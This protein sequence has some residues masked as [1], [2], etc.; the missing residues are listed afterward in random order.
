M[1]R[2]QIDFVDFGGSLNGKT[3]IL[4]CEMTDLE[5][6][7]A[8]ILSPLLNKACEEAVQEMARRYPGGQLDMKSKDVKLL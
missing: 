8:D 5:K 1:I 3:S 4:G 2:I 6:E 7:Q